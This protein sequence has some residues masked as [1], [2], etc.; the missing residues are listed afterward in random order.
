MLLKIIARALPLLA[1][2]LTFESRGEIISEEDCPP[3]MLGVLAGNLQAIITSTDQT[4]GQFFILQTTTGQ[5]CFIRT[6]RGVL[7]ETAM[8]NCQRR[9]RNNE[10]VEQKPQA[11]GTQDVQPRPSHGQT[12]QATTKPNTPRPRPNTPGRSGWSW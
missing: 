2:I 7:I 3:E 1:L 11:Q 5:S 10:R 6:N 8:A 4:D 9:P 12:Y